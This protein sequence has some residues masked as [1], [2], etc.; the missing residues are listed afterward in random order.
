MQQTF[1]SWL[2]EQAGRNDVVGDLAYDAMS[3]KEVPMASCSR[4]EWESHLRERGACDGALSALRQAW[5]EYSG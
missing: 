2:V 5:R 3:D 1:Y 4:K